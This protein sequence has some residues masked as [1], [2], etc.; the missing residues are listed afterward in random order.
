[1]ETAKKISPF[2]HEYKNTT[3]NETITYQ[4]TIYFT[5]CNLYIEFFFL[6]FFSVF[7]FTHI[8]NCLDAYK[9]ELKINPHNILNII[10]NNILLVNAY[11]INL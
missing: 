7:I 10:K 2:F 5:I 3:R 11:E 4:C 6:Y 8:Q 1:M 9:N